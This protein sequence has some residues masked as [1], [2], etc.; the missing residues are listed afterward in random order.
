MKTGKYILL[1]AALILASCEK[2]VIEFDEVSL[3]DQAVIQLHYMVPLASVNAIYNIYRIDI[4][5][6]NVSNDQI[7]ITQ[8]GTQPAAGIG[9]F[10]TKSGNTNLKL[11]MRETVMENGVAKSVDK[12]V[13]D[14]DVVLASGVQ[15]VVITDFDAA[16]FVYPGEVTWEVDTKQFDADTVAYLKFYNLMYETPGVPT[17]LKLQYQYQYT[18]HPIYVAGDEIPEGK[19]LGDATGDTSKSPWLDLGKPVGF[20]ECT[21]WQICPV[22]RTTYIST[23][24]A[25]VDFR[26]VVTEGGTV[27]VD[28]DADGLLY[29]YDRSSAKFMTYT[30]YWTEYV[31]RRRHHFF[32]GTRNGAPGFDVPSPYYALY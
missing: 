13:Y 8:Y 23:G 18:I 7:S 17:K 29:G 20:G 15:N 5:G 31:G 2:N 25:R 24:S 1:A 12:L 21:G 26:I 9:G 3:T 28:M 6:V 14:K 30:D 22:K 16:P 32:V 4:N 10:I 27:G 19:A 11:Y